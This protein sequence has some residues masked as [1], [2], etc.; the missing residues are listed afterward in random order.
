MKVRDEDEIVFSCSAVL[1][2]NDDNTDP[3]EN[4]GRSKRKSLP[5]KRSGEITEMRTV[6]RFAES[7]AKSNFL[8]LSLLLFI[9]FLEIIINFF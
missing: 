9:Y 4:E 1:F 3:C 5:Q 7:S 6:I 2:D 8:N